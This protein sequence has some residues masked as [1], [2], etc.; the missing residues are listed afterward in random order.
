[1]DGQLRR[2]VTECECSTADV[3]EVEVYAAAPDS[4]TVAENGHVAGDVDGT[5]DVNVLQKCEHTAGCGCVLATEGMCKITCGTVCTTVK[6]YSGTCIRSRW[7]GTPDCK[8]QQ[9]CGGEQSTSQDWFYRKYGEH[10]VSHICR[11]HK[12]IL[13]SDIPIT[14]FFQIESF[15]DMIEK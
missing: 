4:M 3:D 13:Q 14:T 8:Q 10:P 6:R 2:V 5:G 12:K 15:R 11:F 9:Y 1:M 7:Y